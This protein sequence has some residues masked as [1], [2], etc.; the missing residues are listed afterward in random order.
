MHCTSAQSLYYNYT[1][2]NMAS[3]VAMGKGPMTNPDTYIEN[4][5]EEGESYVINMHY[6]DDSTGFTHSINNSFSESIH[7]CTC[8]CIHVMAIECLLL[9]YK[10]RYSSFVFNVLFSKFPIIPF[11]FTLF[12]PVFTGECYNNYH[13]CI[14]R[15]IYVLHT[16]NI[17]VYS[18]THIHTIT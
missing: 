4:F 15:I 17:I 7:I 18:H 3:Q 9:L 12:F 5:V 14:T 6:W 1:I 8:T 10:R 2:T 13:I 11:L 16:V